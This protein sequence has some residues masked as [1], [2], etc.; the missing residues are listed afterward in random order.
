MKQWKWDCFKRLKVQN[1]NEVMCVLSVAEIIIITIMLLKSYI[2]TA[3]CENC[4]Q[5]SYPLQPGYL[6]CYKN[7]SRMRS[8]S[9]KM[10][11]SCIAISLIIDSI[12]VRTIPGKAGTIFL[13]FKLKIVLDIM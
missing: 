9:T 5:L 3:V 6:W 7:T 12:I 13:Y 11:H 1:K 2:L 10:L 8:I 4:S